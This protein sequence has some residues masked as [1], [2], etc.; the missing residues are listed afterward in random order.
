MK[1]KTLIFFSISCWILSLFL[2]YA[3]L[4]EKNNLF[5]LLYLKNIDFFLRYRY[6]QGAPPSA[7]NEILI[8]DVETETI[9]RLQ[10]RWPI[11]RGI[12]AALLKAIF[13]PSA[14]PLAAGFDLMFS[15]PSAQPEADISLA[16]AF[17]NSENVIIV[18]SFEAGG[19]LRL[20]EKLF[21]DSVKGVGFIDYPR[22]RD[23]LIRRAY[24]FKRMKGEILELPFVLKVFALVKN[25][26]LKQAFYAQ[27]DNLLKIPALE[28]SQKGFTIPLIA[29]KKVFW[30]NYLAKMGDFEVVP[31]WKVLASPDPAAICKD[32]II[33]VGS[34]AEIFHDN[35]PTPLGIMPGVAINAN[36][37]L[38]LLSG[39]FLNNLPP[40]LNFLILF[41]A[42]C[43]IALFNYY[44]NA[45]KSLVLSVILLLSAF[46]ASIFLI[47][48]D[49]IFDFFGFSLI[50]IISLISTSAYKYFSIVIENMHLKKLAVSDGLT[51]L[52]VFRYFKVKLTSEVKTALETGKD[53]SLVIFD[54]DHFKNFNDTYGHNTGNEILKNFALI[55]KRG[56][57]HTDTVARFGGEEFVAILPASNLAGAA[58]Y[59]EKIR[60]MAEDFTYPSGDK[61]LR[62]T[63][64]AG[65]STL[66]NLAKKTAEELT[67]AADRALYRAK[68]S[69]RNRVAIEESG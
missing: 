64:S 46:Y 12:H 29:G 13:T 5:H 32:K 24:A 60:K 16:N 30:I 34:S 1:R 42:A 47:R 2:V 3:F 43:G 6:N 17:K 58:K 25:L 28:P 27:K 53:L 65:V 11:S 9:K 63:V 57:R 38:S 48:K 31:L 21:V 45:V 68:K 49:M 59:A 55:L 52:Y 8:I 67:S 51:G 41:S 4:V 37:L 33:L 15:G 22:D 44:K 39:R 10:Q 50:V 40:V 69:G 66:S 14:K 56:S 26:N 54:I 35:H 62:F 7:I 23:I 20:P 61:V 36:L 19:R 18:S